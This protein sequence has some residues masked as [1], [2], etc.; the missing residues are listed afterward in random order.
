MTAIWATQIVLQISLGTG[1]TVSH[2]YRSVHSARYRGRLPQPSSPP[3]I[4]IS[5]GEKAPG[6]HL[7]GGRPLGQLVVPSTAR[8]SKYYGE[9]G[10]QR[11][12]SS[13]S[14]RTLR[15]WWATSD[16]RLLACQFPECHKAMP[17]QRPVIMEGPSRNYA[18]GSPIMGGSGPQRCKSTDSKVWIGLLMPAH[19]EV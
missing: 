14:T 6:P 12:L 5:G 13:D 19:L 2:I 3:W 15:G 9:G 8:S 16:D 11:L 18:L 4:G 10:G 17:S 1:A 7:R